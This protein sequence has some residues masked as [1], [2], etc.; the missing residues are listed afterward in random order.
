M[1]KS[2]PGFQP[3]VMDVR[4]TQESQHSVQGFDDLI[5]M[6]R[7]SANSDAEAIALAEGMGKLSKRVEAIS[8]KLESPQSAKSIGPELVQLL[9]EL[10]QHRQAIIQL[11]VTWRELPEY[12]NYNVALNNFRLLLNQW[13]MERSVNKDQ[14]VQF[15]DFEALAW[16]TLGEGMLLLDMHRHL[17]ARAFSETSQS[18][19]E[20]RRTEQ[21]SDWWNK[22][23]GN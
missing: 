21:A 9:T 19:L 18:E 3:T 11:D 22:L 10:R 2:K 4:P 12:A 13:L 1:S 14:A 15:D 6:M 17:S 20:P 8:P 23:R 16:R 7:E 5:R